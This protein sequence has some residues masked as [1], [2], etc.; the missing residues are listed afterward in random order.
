LTR[1]S[2][3]LSGKTTPLCEAIE[4]HEDPRLSPT[5]RTNCQRFSSAQPTGVSTPVVYLFG[6]EKSRAK[7]S[8][9]RGHAKHKGHGE[10]ILVQASRE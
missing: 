9:V 8:K 10:F 3:M 7:N 2:A 6:G 1:K 4:L 5:W